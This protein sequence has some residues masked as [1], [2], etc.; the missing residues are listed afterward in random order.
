MNQI[1][2]QLDLLRELAECSAVDEMTRL[3]IRKL[4]D[5]EIQKREGS[6]EKIS[7]DLAKLAKDVLVQMILHT[8]RL[9]LPNPR[10]NPMDLAIHREQYLV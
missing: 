5:D 4:L 6:L 3:T 7:E 9:G 8:A 10:H 1:L 2:K